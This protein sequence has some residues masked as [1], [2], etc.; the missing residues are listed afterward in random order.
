MTL[1]LPL[2]VCELRRACMLSAAAYAAS[3]PQTWDRLQSIGYDEVEPFNVEGTMGIIA[4]SRSIQEIAIAFTGTKDLNDVIDDVSTIPEVTHGAHVHYGFYK[5]LEPV[6]LTLRI[7]L[8]DMITRHGHP[9]SILVTGHSL[10]GALAALVGGWQHDYFTAP[11]RLIT[12]GQPRVGWTDWATNMDQFG[13]LYLRVVHDMDFVPCVPMS[14]FH[15]TGNLLHLTTAGVIIGPVGS[16]WR[17]FV[18][19]LRQF[20]SYPRT[21]VTDHFM[22]NYITAVNALV[23]SWKLP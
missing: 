9:A 8:Q 21:G 1:S 6:D 16:G 19:W 15:H 7:K 4:W 3:V 18:H 11:V 14:P 12:F 13:P 10:G 17:T 22:T 23:P 2:G 5:A 20:L